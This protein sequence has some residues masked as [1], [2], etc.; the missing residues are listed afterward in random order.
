MSTGMIG[1]AWLG[2]RMRKRLPQEV[3]ERVFKRLITV[4]ALRMVCLTV[5]EVRP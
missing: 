4:L 3:F 5:L 1:G 2:T